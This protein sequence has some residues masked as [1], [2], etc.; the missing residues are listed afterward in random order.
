MK[1]QNKHA[2]SIVPALHDIAIG[3]VEGKASLLVM[4][5]ETGKTAGTL[6]LD[7]RRQGREESWGGGGV[8]RRGK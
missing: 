6:T 8:I 5:L 3:G 2:G 7:A 1:E 4:E